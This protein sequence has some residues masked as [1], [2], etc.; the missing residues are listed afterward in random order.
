MNAYT[1]IRV[2]EDPTVM[3]GAENRSQDVPRSDKKP[4]RRSLN[5]K[6][7]EEEQQERQKDAT[8]DHNTH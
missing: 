8:R 4:L 7:R 1:E 2:F 6:R 3:L 5:N